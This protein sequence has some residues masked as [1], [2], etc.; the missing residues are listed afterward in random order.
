M[1]T[2]LARLIA[3]QIC[4]H[5]CMAGMRLAAPLLALREGY[6]AAAVGILLALFALTQ[7][8][9]ALPAGRYA[10]R[11]GLKRPVGYAVV[12]AVVGAAGALVWPAFP[13]LCLAALM[14]GGATGA[15]TIALQRHV[16]RAAHDSTQLRQV[17]SWLAIG[18]A[19]SNFVGPFCAGLLIDHAGPMA[20]STEGYRAAFALMAVLPIATWFWVRATVELPPVIA[21]AGGVRP[22]AWDLLAE[23]GF[24]RLLIV[25][26]LLSSCWD[27]HT[28]V[29]PLLGHER[30]L[31]ASVIGTILGAFAIAAA[32]IR[33]LMPLVAA[34][35]REAVVVTWAMVTTAVL[36][37]V[38]PLLPNP[39]ALGLCSV[40]LGFALGSVQ[41][42]IMSMLHQ[43][44]PSHR[45]GEALGLRLMAINGSSVLM[46]V[47]FGSAG[48]LIG[49]AG[50]FWVV[51]AVVG[52]GSRLA[53]RLGDADAHSA[54]PH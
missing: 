24:R 27:V 37:A 47:L 46:P 33:V 48:A 12:V 6:S 44:T 29:V 13:M 54:V 23:P 3:G 8:F 39:W 16:G 5:A 40:L 49:V 14:T 42:M 51:G 50:L 34:H 36:F 19:V 15:A 22:R 30:G 2:A 35:L 1:N 11:H 7:V 17:F 31:S 41:P 43:I 53:A 21:A 10:D 9:L 4:I 20:G 52:G 28:F 38:Y 45:H 25:N 26:W 18:P 32:V